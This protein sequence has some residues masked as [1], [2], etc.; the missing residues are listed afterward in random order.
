MSERQCDVVKARWVLDELSIRIGT[1][2]QDDNRI[3]FFIRNDDGWGPRCLAHRRRE[4]AV[5]VPFVKQ[6]PRRPIYLLLSDTTL[7]SVG[8]IFE[9]V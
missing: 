7:L 3:N 2:A 8:K 6:R 9:F 4:T 1:L 5:D